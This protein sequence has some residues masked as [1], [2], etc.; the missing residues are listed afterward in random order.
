MRRGS[1]VRPHDHAL[2]DDDAI[3][4]DD[5]GDAGM[6]FRV[7]VLDSCV[8]SVIGKRSFTLTSV[9]LPESAMAKPGAVPFNQ[10]RVP[11][12]RRVC[13]LLHFQN[14]LD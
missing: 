4:D 8:T 12:P 13:F 3:G 2:R 7:H 9:L 6:Q 11:R 1:R 5:A 10:H 14:Y